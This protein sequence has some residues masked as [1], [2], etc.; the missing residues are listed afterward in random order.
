MD[1]WMD[2]WMDNRCKQIPQTLLTES[3]ELKTAQPI[4]L[5]LPRNT[6]LP[7]P[8]FLQ[9]VAWQFFLFSYEFLCCHY[10]FPNHLSDCAQTW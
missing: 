2:G 1:G 5:K 9:Q 10:F 3:A 7:K 6:L 8:S 4:A